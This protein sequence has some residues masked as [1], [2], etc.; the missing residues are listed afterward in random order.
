M[1][2][3]LVIKSG[4]GLHHIW[5]HSQ[6]QHA[7]TSAVGLSAEKQSTVVESEQPK[8]KLKARVDGMLLEDKQFDPE[9]VEDEEDED[10]EETEH[11]ARCMLCLSKRKVP[12]C[13]ECG[14]VC[15]CHV[16]FFLFKVE[17]DGVLLKSAGLVSW[18]GQGKRYVF[19]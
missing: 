10:E 11:V 8:T 5:S 18:D 19:F 1:A 6:Q 14:H 4:M 3:Q 7:D 15:E 17:A 12:T 16:L 9:H 13:T 2:L